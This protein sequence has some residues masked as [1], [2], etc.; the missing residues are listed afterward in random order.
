MN[1]LYWKD[2]IKYLVIFTVLLTL[3]FQSFPID[4][5]VMKSWM[6]WAFPAVIFLEAIFQKIRELHI[7]W[8]LLII[9]FAGF[10]MYSL[11]VTLP[12]VVLILCVLSGRAVLS[13]SGSLGAA[14]WIYLEI[15]GKFQFF[16]FL[17]KL[18][19]GWLIG[20]FIVITVGRYYEMRFY[21]KKELA[22]NEVIHGIQMEQ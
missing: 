6:F 11:G 21:W 20:V 17:D 16:D 8:G 9:V 14:I 10:S 4:A 15:T 1:I 5:S 13:M 19:L 2:S 12:H 22:E 3:L 18:H 7:F